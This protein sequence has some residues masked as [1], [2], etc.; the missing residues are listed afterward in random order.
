MGKPIVRISPRP[1]ICADLS[2]EK[3]AQ[4]NGDLIVW[5]YGRLLTE[6]MDSAGKGQPHRYVEVIFRQLHDDIPATFKIEHLPIALLGQLRIGTIWRKGLCVAEMQ[7]NPVQFHRINFTEGAWHFSSLKTAAQ[8][9]LPLPFTDQDYALPRQYGLDS[10][11][12]LD[13]PLPGGKNLLI[14]CIEVLSRCYSHSS[15]IPR[16][17]TTYPWEHVLSVLYSSTE[18]DPCKWIVRP[19]KGF[20]ADDGVYLAWTLYDKYAESRSKRIY[21][22]LNVGK[23]NQRGRPESAVALQVAMWFQG[24][25]SLECKGL[26]VNDGATFLCLEVLARSEPTSPTFEWEEIDYERQ[27]DGHDAAELIPRRS[28]I[29]GEEELDPFRITGTQDPDRNAGKTTHADPKFRIL[30]QRCKFRRTKVTKPQGEKYLHAGEM[31]RYPLYSTGDPSSKGKD[32]G[33]VAFN[34]A[35]VGLGG[36][37]NDLWQ[38]LQQIRA[39]HPSIIQRIEWFTEEQGF[40]TS[41]P[42]EL[43]PLPHVDDCERRMAIRWISHRHNP[44]GTR[45]ILIVRVSALYSQ[46]YLLE[47]QRKKKRVP[48]KPSPQASRLEVADPLLQ[49]K[50]ESSAGLAIEFPS[51]GVAME[52]IAQIC[53]HIAYVRGK[54]KELAK[55]REYPHHIMRHTHSGGNRFPLESA[56]MNM[57]ASMGVTLPSAVK[58]DVPT[59]LAHSAPEMVE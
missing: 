12:M 18:K 15:E 21:S 5:W 24:L 54:F 7:I 31:P 9:G 41:S 58:A 56:V 40:Q 42:P 19:G 6:V 4:A 47:V 36:V 17:L 59:D 23:I 26:W 20:K 52:E 51:D 32:I 29:N 49:T 25:H 35:V 2:G 3:F 55:L 34:S 13:F 44:S 33:K 14:P 46:L 53:S 39:E 11:W 50:E 45:G 37:I 22:D 38:A 27:D 28:R 16:L 30:G 10:S 57:F 1:A 43:Q 8:Q 48:V